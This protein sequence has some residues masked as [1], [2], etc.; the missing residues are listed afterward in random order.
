MNNTSTIEG[1]GP[2]MSSYC[3]D[4]PNVLYFTEGKHG[5]CH[6]LEEGKLCE[7]NVQLMEVVMG[8]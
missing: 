3:G 6:D 2:Q 7:R 4:Q 8:I 5:R 1:W